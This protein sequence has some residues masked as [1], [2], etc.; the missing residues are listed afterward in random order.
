VCILRV[1]GLCLCLRL[2]MCRR[3]GSRLLT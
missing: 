3:W 2:C 1:C